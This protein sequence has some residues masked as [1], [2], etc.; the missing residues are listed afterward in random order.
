MIAAVL[1]ASSCFSRASV[2]SSPSLMT[3]SSGVIITHF[4]CIGL[5]PAPADIAISRVC[6]SNVRIL[7]M[8]NR[9]E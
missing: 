6:C 2:S 4:T 3:L 9:I 5:V 8:L 1:S 7:E